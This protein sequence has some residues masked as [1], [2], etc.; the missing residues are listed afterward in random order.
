[1]PK[2][3]LNAIAP[4]TGSYY[5]EPYASQMGERSFRALGD[6][7]GLTQFGVVLVELA[8]GATSSLRHWHTDEDEFVYVLSGDLVLIENEGETP[9]GA[10]EAAGFKAGDDNGHHLQNRSDAPAQFIC[11][12]TRA[13]NDTVFYSDVD[14]MLRKAGGKSRFALRNGRPAD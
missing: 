13:Q 6:A 12:G 1:M 4:F 10:G 2:I 3:D 5:P 9:L 7:A 11:I 8:P 14:L